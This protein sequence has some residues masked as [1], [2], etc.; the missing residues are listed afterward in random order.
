[1]I[2]ISYETC[3]LDHLLLLLLERFQAEIRKNIEILLEK[4]HITR[5]RVIFHSAVILLKKLKLLSRLHAEENKTTSARMLISSI[6]TDP[7]NVRLLH[8]VIC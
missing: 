1:M 7:L 3:L 6:I 2:L 8:D 4:G 5:F